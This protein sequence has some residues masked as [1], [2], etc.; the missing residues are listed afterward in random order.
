VAVCTRDR[1]T[2]LRRC[3]KAILDLDPE[4]TQVLV[5]DNAP[6][7]DETRIAAQACG[8]DYVC[9]PSP[10]LNRARQLALRS[11]TGDIVLL[12]DDDVTVDPH[13]GAAMLE[14][15]CAP[16][17]AAV[18][19]LV[20]P[21]ELETDAQ[22][23]FEAR[24]GFGRGFSRKVHDLRTLRP[25]RAGSMGAGASMGLRR[26]VACSL[27]VFDARLDGGTRA[28]S[29]GDTY[30]LYLVLRNGWQV[31]YT[32]DALAWHEHRRDHESMTST[33]AGYSTGAYTWLLK[34]LLEHRELSAARE[35]MQ[36]FRKHHLARL[37]WALTRRTDAPDLSV[38]L[39]EIGGVLAA[40]RAYLESR[41]PW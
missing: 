18:T 1:P 19:G 39:A 8:V 35:M 21:M 36:W 32:P 22:E 13:W 4:P 41:R 38:A 9:E 11:A 5:V 27:S 25:V 23:A 34:A 30:A 40:G 6:S 14:P 28:R 15:F 20:M 17:V 37:R 33:L 10:G 26:D 24:G 3:I 16:R 7:N 12:T 31:A 2:Q 29:G